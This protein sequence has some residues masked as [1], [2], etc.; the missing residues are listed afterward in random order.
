MVLKYTLHMSTHMLASLK[1][2][3]APYS[4]H[5]VTFIPSYVVKMPVFHT[6]RLTGILFDPKTPSFLGANLFFRPPGESHGV[7]QQPNW[8]INFVD[9]SI[10]RSRWGD[11]KWRLTPFFWLL[12]GRTKKIN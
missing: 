7:S 3:L 8:L 10:S 2:D 9:R 1:P 6:F 5:T 11:T 4:G 12:R